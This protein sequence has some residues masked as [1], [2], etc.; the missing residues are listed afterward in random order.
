MV[1][2]TSL[3][4]DAIEI[5]GID[6]ACTGPT[7]TANRHIASNRE[8]KTGKTRLGDKKSFFSI[9]PPLTTRN[10][11][12]YSNY[13]ARIKAISLWMRDA[14][15]HPLGKIVRGIAQAVDLQEEDHLFTIHR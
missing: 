8:R 2:D 6:Q 1:T 15:G 5:N 3:S 13:S 11:L 9:L 12:E 7:D 4:T 10:H 14:D